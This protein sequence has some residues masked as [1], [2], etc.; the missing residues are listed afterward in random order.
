MTQNKELTALMKELKILT[1]YINE[2]TQQ[3]QRCPEENR[4]FVALYNERQEYLQEQREL[5]DKIQTIINP[6][7]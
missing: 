4:K 6:K 7:N 2:T 3:M 1:I 5:K